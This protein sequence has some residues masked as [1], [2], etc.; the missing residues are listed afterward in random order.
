MKRRAER[1]AR[2]APGA[3]DEAWLCRPRQRLLQV[4][5][6][7]GLAL[8]GRPELRQWGGQRPPRLSE[9]LG[10]GGWG[11]G[12]PSQRGP[13]LVKLHLAHLLGVGGGW[14][15]VR[16]PDSGVLA[17]LGA[18]WQPR[19]WGKQR[20]AG[21]GEKWRW[22]DLAGPRP[23]PTKFRRTAAGVERG[24]GKVTGWPHP[25]PGHPEKHKG[26]GAS[27]RKTPGGGCPADPRVSRG[28]AAGKLWTAAGGTALPGQREEDAARP[29][30]RQLGRT[31]C[32]APGLKSSGLGPCPQGQVDSLA[33]V[34]PVRCTH[35]G[36]ASPP[37]SLCQRSGKSRW[38]RELES[39]F[40][41]LSDMNRKLKR[42][43]S[44][45]LASGPGSEASPH[46]ERGSSEGHGRPGETRRE[47]PAAD[48]G[49]EIGLAEVGASH[50]PPPRSSPQ[51]T[52][53][54]L[55]DHTWW[56]TVR[57]TFEGAKTPSSPEAG[58]PVSAESLPWGRMASRH[59]L[60][61]LD[62]PP[63]QRDPRGQADRDGLAASRQKQEPERRRPAWLEL[64][65]S[66]ERRLEAQGRDEGGEQSGSK[67]LSQPPPSQAASS[68]DQRK[69]GARE[70]SP[71][72][73]AATS[74][75]YDD[76]GSGHS[77]IIRDRQQQ[78][79]E[80]NQLHK[81]FL[82]EARKRLRE[83]QSEC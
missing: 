54:E 7:G 4:R 76:G 41:E 19:A 15:V 73:P 77:Q 25:P 63:L 57:P 72:S 23:S 17:R 33:Q 31:A 13:G 18:A 38:Q 80:Q 61:R 55:E 29:W 22:E 74:S 36:G 46:G 40:T 1:A 9:V 32:L 42:H 81:Q 30:R 43:L 26:A 79:L 56:K 3:E 21:R 44:L 12:A 71:A 14:A 69:E 75:T 35:G 39:A 67:V 2:L 8:H 10:A 62:T 48:A 45:H 78:I 50:K 16:K 5:E 34:W 52:L 47:K 68:P 28:L 82:E 6:E 11:W 70:P 37:A 59:G 27:S 64:L 66:P 53:S 60:P 24:S 49:T 20:A 51:K 58:T 65:G 83:F